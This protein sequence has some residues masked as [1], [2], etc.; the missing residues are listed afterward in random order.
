M[1]DQLEDL[2][3]QA[4]EWRGANTVPLEGLRH[5]VTR[6][7][8]PTTRWRAVTIAAAVVLAVAVSVGIAVRAGQ[9]PPRPADEPPPTPAQSQAPKPVPVPTGSQPMHYGPTWM[10][11]GLGEDSR[12]FELR[13]AQIVRAVRTWRG[14][15]QELEIAVD[16]VGDAGAV[17]GPNAEVLG[18]PARLD[19][20][21]AAG[22]PG[23]LEWRVDGHRIVLTARVSKPPASTA[24]RIAESVRSDPATLRPAFTT[25]WLPAGLTVITYTAGDSRI[26]VGEPF[27][28]WMGVLT[29]TDPAD[30]QRTVRVAAV[31]GATIPD[32]GE[33]TARQARPATY[34][35]TADGQTLTQRA[36]VGPVVWSVTGPGPEVLPRADLERIFDGVVENENVDLDWLGTRPA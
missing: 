10:P 13:D 21:S 9:A 7:A 23:R 6:P 11:P 26:P 8:A 19:W 14:A 35:R 29:A 30:P 17:T 22:D 25:D 15:G 12:S 4:Q 2:V 36:V 5:R 32:G 28:A 18:G 20:P 31:A 34:L 24:R 27:R 16:L 33:V 1:S 3:R